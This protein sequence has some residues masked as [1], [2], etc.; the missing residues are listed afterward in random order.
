MNISL[1]EIKRIIANTTDKENLDLNLCKEA[2][3]MIRDNLRE[4][5]T[6]LTRPIVSRFI[7][8]CCHQF[9]RFSIPSNWYTVIDSY[10]YFTEYLQLFRAIENKFLDNLLTLEVHNISWRIIND[11][12]NG[13]DVNNALYLSELNLLNNKVMELSQN[14]RKEYF[15]HHDKLVNLMSSIKS[16]RIKTVIISK[17]PV[18][19]VIKKTIIRTVYEGKNLIAY[20]ALYYTTIPLQST[21]A[22]PLQNTPLWCKF[23]AA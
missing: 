15:E 10:Y 21:P 19:P 5:V 16:N 6:E 11:L 8:Y 4:L 9:N 23:L 14:K 1:K 12:S 22:I 18:S 2:F 3:P 17:I 7:Y 20:S 13:S